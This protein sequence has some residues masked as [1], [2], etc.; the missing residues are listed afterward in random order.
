VVR[1]TPRGMST[2]VCETLILSELLVV[3][4]AFIAC[5][6]LIRPQ[7]KKGLKPKKKR[8]PLAVRGRLKRRALA[9]RWR[10][11]TYE[12][13]EFAR[14]CQIQNLAQSEN[15]PPSVALRAVLNDLGVRYQREAICWFDGDLFVILDFLLPDYKLCIEQDGLQHRFQHVYDWE[16][17]KMIAEVLDVRVFRKWNSFFLSPN[18][19]DEMIKVLGIAGA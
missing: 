12:Q 8:K 14:Q 1:E 9:I 5:L 4:L 19:R 18:L 7:P 2:K 17:D 15:S 3:L 11:P 6:M 13:R 10:E 16:R